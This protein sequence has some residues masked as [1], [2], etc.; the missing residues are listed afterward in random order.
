MTHTTR[1]HPQPSELVAQT[2]LRSLDEL[3]GLDITIG[4]DAVGP[5]DGQSVLITVDDVFSNL[6]GPFVIQNCVQIDVWSPR[7]A[8]ELAQSIW[9][10][11]AAA[12]ARRIRAPQFVPH[13]GGRWSL[14]IEFD[15]ESSPNASDNSH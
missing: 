4:W 3:K 8:E 13:Q 6:P 1:V 10:A 2:W 14:D 5:W 12:Q 15:V 11:A 9:R 7:R